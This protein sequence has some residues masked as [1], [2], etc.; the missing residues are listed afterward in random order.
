[1][2]RS[3][4]RY[5]QGDS[6]QTTAATTLSAGGRPGGLGT[7]AKAAQAGGSPRGRGAVASGDGALVVLGQSQT[8]LQNEANGLANLRAELGG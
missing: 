7:V 1:M 6:N 3:M 8:V 5:A 4:R 2:A